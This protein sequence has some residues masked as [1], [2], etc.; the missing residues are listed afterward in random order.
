MGQSEFSSFDRNNDGNLSSQELS[1]ALIEAI[2][3]AGYRAIF[4]KKID[5]D[6]ILY[7]MNVFDVAHIR[8]SALDF[9]KQNGNDFRYGVDILNDK[10]V[11]RVHDAALKVRSIVGRPENSSVSE[12]LLS[13]FFLSSHRMRDIAKDLLQSDR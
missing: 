13:G 3:V 4:R 12:V 1:D 11:A 6:N 10:D 5:S 9:A 7:S 8:R 2:K